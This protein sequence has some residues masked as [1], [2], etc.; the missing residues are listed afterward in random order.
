MQLIY[1]CNNGNLT[2]KVF[3]E[4]LGAKKFDKLQTILQR[5]AVN[6]YF[7]NDL[8]SHHSQNE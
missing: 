6:F 2:I 4:K 3:V 7:T 8:M 1:I 5:V